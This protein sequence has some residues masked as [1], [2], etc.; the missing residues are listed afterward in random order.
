MKKVDPG[1]RPAGRGE[2]AKSVDDY[3]AALPRDARA[4]LEKLRET[5][6]AAAPEP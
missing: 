2:P 3:L 1:A 5:I 6:R 4:A